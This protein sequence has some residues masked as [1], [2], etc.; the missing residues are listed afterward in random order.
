MLAVPG[1]EP[2]LKAVCVVPQGMEEGTEADLRGREFG[3]ITGEQVVFRVFSAS[4]RAG[5]P[6]GQ[7][8]E[9]PEDLA[10]TASLELTL[11]PLEGRSGEM[12]PVRLRSVIT[13]L[14]I[15]ELWMRHEPSGQQWKLEYNIRG[16][17]K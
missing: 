16:Q 14:G 13:E 11:P 6:V 9:D 10:E 17:L 2:P 3:L 4:V 1:I 8:V 5:D 12:L 15:L 7:G